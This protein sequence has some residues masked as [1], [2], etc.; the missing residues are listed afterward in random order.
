MKEQRCFEFFKLRYHQASMLTDQ[1]RP[2]PREGADTF[3]TRSTIQICE[4]SC[5]GPQSMLMKTQPT[6]KRSNQKAMDLMIFRW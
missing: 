5:M 2:R 3:G 4:T 1:L 6:K